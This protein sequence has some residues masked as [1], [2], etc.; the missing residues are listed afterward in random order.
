MNRVPVFPERFLWGTATAATQVEGYIQNEW[1]D[2]QAQDGRTCNIACDHY[3][4]YPEDI[5]WMARLGTNAYRMG[6][7]WSR[8]QSSPNAPLNKTE[9]DRYIDVL[10][11]LRATGIT[12]MIVLHHF[13][14]PP[15]ISATGGWTNSATISAFVNYVEQL[16]VVLRD[17]VTLW[18]TFNEPDT[19]ASLAYLLGG[20]PPC[21]KWNFGAFRQVIA[22]MAE[23]HVRAC[24]V[25]RKHSNS[26]RTLEVGIAKNWTHFQPHNGL[27]LWDHLPALA[28]HH[29][30]N[31]HVM[32]AFFGRNRHRAST[33]IGVNYYGRVRFRQLRPL[34]PIDEGARRQLRDL[35]LEHDDMIERHP[36]GLAQVL[37]TLHQRFNLP[38]YLTENGSSSDDESFRI[39]DL[40]A[41]LQ[42]IRHAISQGV[43]V[44]GFFYWSLLDNFE[45]H[46]GYTKKFG[47]LKVDFDDPQLPRTLKPIGE[48][49]RS[50]ILAQRN[51]HCPAAAGQANAPY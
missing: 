25:I 12:P 10:D 26:S 1:T 46:F 4:R 41:H 5:Q 16:V 51:D 19:Y 50:S 45:W 2:F 7:E 36:T 29:S 40:T 37:Q 8:L 38:L 33:F 13:S 39:R 14:N 24:E 32:R 42:V 44:R 27:A 47:L 34:V 49:Y 31:R 9:L 3:H 15:W 22:N 48:F 18:N 23:A 6:I 11:Q 28:C 21:R 30:F 43:D 35:R 17:R 20:F